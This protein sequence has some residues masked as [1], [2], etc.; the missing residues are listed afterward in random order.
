MII[1]TNGCFDILHR[2]HIELLD[3]CKQLAGRDGMVI[4]GLN[5]DNSVRENKGIGRPIIGE[6]DR[7]IILEALTY[8]DEVIIFNELTPYR[9][10]S[11]LQPDIIVKGHDWKN[12]YVI[13]ASFAEEVRFAPTN[14]SI[15]T[16]K[17]IQRCYPITR[18]NI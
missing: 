2:Q 4:V 14:D 17:I 12:E 11:Q 8:V 13:G 6:K 10:L 15:T 18:T 9:L 7:R 1:F 5:S 16:T 3:Y